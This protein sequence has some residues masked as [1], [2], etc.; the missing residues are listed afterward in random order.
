[1]SKF[2]DAGYTKDTKFRVIDNYGKF[3][4]G[5]IVTILEDDGSSCPTF[6]D[7]EG[8]EEFMILPDEDNP[9]LEVFIEPKK[10]SLFG[11]KYRV[12]PETSKLLQ[13]TVFAAGGSWGYV[14]G[15]TIK[16]LEQPC[17]YVEKDGVLG[18]SDSC[19]GSY[20]FFNS[21]ELQEATIEIIQTIK[22]TDFP[23][24]S[25]EQVKYNEALEAFN[26][27]KEALEK[28]EPKK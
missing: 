18:Y 22:I 15:K 16:H 20:E 27:A 12:T 8:N 25:Q 13:E 19:D 11:R 21:N 7:S 17:L 6:T 26:K 1:M 24:V 2:I 9:E 5:D 3:K 4:V 14:S 10:T 28:L 23:V